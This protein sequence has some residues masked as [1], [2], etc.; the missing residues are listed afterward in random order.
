M[1]GKL[2][3]TMPFEMSHGLG[4]SHRMVSTAAAPALTRRVTFAEDPPATSDF[5]LSVFKVEVYVYRCAGLA[6][7]RPGS[8]GHG[9]RVIATEIRHPHTQHVP[10][11]LLDR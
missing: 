9:R 8:P 3:F 4:S 7:G 1:S 5:W 10:V 2:K 6:C 11:A